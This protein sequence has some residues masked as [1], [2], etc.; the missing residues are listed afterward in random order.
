V[1]MFVRLT[2]PGLLLLLVAGPVFAGD[3]VPA[4]L[5]QAVA[6]NA[7]AYEKDVPAVVLLNDQTVSVGEDGR[8]VTTRNYAVRILIREGRDYAMAKEIYHT[9][10]GKVRDLRAWLIRSSGPVKRYGKDEILDVALSTDDVYNEYRAKAIFAHDDAD[11]GAVFGYQ[12]VSEDRSIFSQFEW[13]FQERIPSLLSRFTLALPNGWR[14]TSVTF[15]HEKIEPKITGASYTW[16]LRDSAPIQPEPMSPPVSKI[17]ARLAVSYF[18]APGSTN[19]TV[20]TFADWAEVA[21]WMSELED[22]QVT[23][24]DA[25]TA[26][27][28]EL[29]ANAK[30]ELEK[31]QAIGR[32]AQSVKYI[33]IQIGLGRGGGYRPHT[34]TEV[35]AKS[36]GDCKDKANLMRAM[37]KVVGITA[38]PVSIYSGDPDYVRSEWPSPQQFN[39][40]IIAIKV[41]E[42]LPGQTVFEHARLGRLL[43]FDPTAEETPVGDLPSYLQGS[44]ALIDARESDALIKM[45]VT[46]PE[47]NLLDRQIDASIDGRGSLSASVREKANGQWASSYRREFRNQSRSDYVKRIEG[48]VTAGATAARVSKVEPLDGHPLN[49]FDLNVDFV[50]PSYGQL[51]QDRLLVFKPAIVS[52]RESLA[53]TASRRQQPV[54]L[55]SNAY[56]EI[57]RVTLPQGFD[58]DEMPDALK[59][60]TAFGSYATSYEVK[61]G[62]LVFTRKLVQRAT[63]IPADQYNSVRSFFEKIRAAEQAPVVLARK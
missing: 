63:T 27:A 34:A 59:L 60:D 1:I 40:C 49:R 45:P 17:A 47:A 43:I 19:P 52:R 54:V 33:S 3:D 32:Y 10:T 55:K 26:K 9:D 39:H 23:A 24:N 14:A 22:P 6:T 53:L 35:F 29:T 7:P 4:W 16:E 44:L 61:E 8:V 42:D 12:I 62:Q 28:R 20:K 48:W 25:L 11:A 38:F 51:M 2:L 15:N 5:Q 46:S 50:A 13:D 37:L 31:I 30:T 41:S 57:V 56:S 58:I 18:P 21:A 36:Y